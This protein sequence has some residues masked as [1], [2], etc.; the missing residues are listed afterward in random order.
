MLLLDTDVLSGIMRLN[1]D[2]KLAAWVRLQNPA[3][4]LMSSI[5]IFEM[6]AGI[7]RKPLGKRRNAL[8]VTFQHLVGV[9]FAGRIVGFDTA[10]GDAAGGIR[11]TQLATGRNV[12]V[13]DSQIAGIAKANGWSV[14]T[15]N[16]K[17]FANLGIALV[18]PWA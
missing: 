8:E 3:Q 5:S 14:G 4:L 2:P 13:P 9:S 16:T 17:D 18:D 7:D 11:A 10:A 15:R 1:L 12:S 6:R